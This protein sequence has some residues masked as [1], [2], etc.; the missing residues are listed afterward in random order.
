MVASIMTF[1]YQANNAHFLIVWT[2]IFI[3]IIDSEVFP[4]NIKNAKSATV[5]ELNMCTTENHEYNDGGGCRPQG[6]SMP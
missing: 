1:I 6:V 5:I 4:L 3:G 2:S